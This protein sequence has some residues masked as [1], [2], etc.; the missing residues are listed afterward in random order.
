MLTCTAA[1]HAPAFPEEMLLL[2]DLRALLSQK[3]TR[4]LQKSPGKAV[5]AGAGGRLLT[6][7]APSTAPLFPLPHTLLVPSGSTQ[8]PAL[9][10]TLRKALVSITICLASSWPS[11]QLHVLAASDYVCYLTAIDRTAIGSLLLNWPIC[12]I[13]CFLHASFSRTA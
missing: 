12:A 10:H 11:S 13:H 3:T 6:R 4:P 8:V 7:T 1:G 5:S 2:Q 9:C